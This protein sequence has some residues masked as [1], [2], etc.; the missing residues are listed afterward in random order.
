MA[1]PGPDCPQSPG[2]GP[3]ANQFAYR[4]DQQT[5]I[6]DLLNTPKT[7]QA[8]AYAM[9][10]LANQAFSLARTVEAHDRALSARLDHLV[11]IF[12]EEAIIEGV[13]AA[14]QGLPKRLAAFP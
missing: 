5:N 1:C 14:P 4:V 9:L 6:A 8:N 7:P 11:A 13:K 12:A 3:S 2:G 10:T